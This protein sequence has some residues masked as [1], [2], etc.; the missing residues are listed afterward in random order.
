MRAK[1]RLLLSLVKQLLVVIQEIAS[2]DRAIKHPFFDAIRTRNSGVRC[3]VRASAWLHACWLN[4]AMIA[5]RYA[6]ATSVQALA[7]TA[8]VPFAKRQLRQSAQTL[9][10]RETPAQRPAPVCLAI[11]AARSLGVGL[12]SAQTGEG[13]THSVAVRALA[14]VWVR[15]LYRMWVNKTSYQTA[16]FEAAR[17]AHAPRPHAA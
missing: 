16:T 8:P 13:K 1:S 12:L 10:V 17:L 15:I 4:G 5:A 9:R 3:L 2:Y 11:D 14:N 6:D 7:G